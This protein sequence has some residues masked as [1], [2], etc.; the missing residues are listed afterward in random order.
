M[1]AS[2]YSYRVMV[3]SISSSCLHGR[4]VP[5]NPVTYLNK[6]FEL[7]GEW[8]LISMIKSKET[9][10]MQYYERTKLP[11]LESLIPTFGKYSYCQHAEM[12]QN[13]D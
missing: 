2:V 12:S 7:K 3:K 4:W 9:R 6:N 1:L 5:S 13:M 8:G 11:N 10:S